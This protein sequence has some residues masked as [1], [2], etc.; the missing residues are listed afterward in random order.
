MKKTTESP[1]ADTRDSFHRR[2]ELMDDFESEFKSIFLSFSQTLFAIFNEPLIPQMDQTASEG[3]N[4]GSQDSVPVTA[5]FALLLVRRLEPA[6]P[7]IPLP[8]AIFQLGWG[9]VKDSY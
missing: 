6:G 4:M 1:L 8:L 5:S 9:I 2:L 7:L 3:C